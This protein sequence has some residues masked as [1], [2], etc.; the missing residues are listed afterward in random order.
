MQVYNSVPATIAK[1]AS[2]R[3]ESPNVSHIST[4]KWLWTDY[5]WTPTRPSWSG[6]ASWHST[7]ARQ[8]RCDATPTVSCRVRF[9]GHWPWRRSVQSVIHGST[10]HCR[11]PIF[12]Y[13]FVSCV[14]SNDLGRLTLWDHWYK[15]LYTVGWNLDYCNALL[16]RIADT[17]VKR[18]QSVQNAAAWL[19]SS[20][21]W[22][23]AGTISHHSYVGFPI[24]DRF[25]NPGIRDWEI[26]N[27]GISA[28]LRDWPK[29][30]GNR[31][32]CRL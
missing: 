20:W 25:S 4:G 30:S 26:L 5:S 11:F 2:L 29:C 17:Q 3:V 27:P 24:P 19:V 16:A 28:G 8:A 7:A 12:L 21:C 15:R 32:L 18:L 9:S 13:K 22:I 1:D 10:G 23:D 14:S 31:L 6:F